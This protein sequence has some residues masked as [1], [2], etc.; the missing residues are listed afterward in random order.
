MV[1]ALD[2]ADFVFPE[3]DFLQIYKSFQALDF[4]NGIFL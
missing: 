3:F 1:E 4:G 2:L